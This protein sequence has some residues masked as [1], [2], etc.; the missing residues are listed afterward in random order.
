M[1]QINTNHKELPSNMPISLLM[2]FI[3]SSQRGLVNI[4]A[5]WFVVSMNS[6][7][8]SPFC[9]WSR[10][11]WCLMSMCLV[12]ECWIGFLDKFIALVLSHLIGMWSR[13]NPKSISCCLIHKTWAQQQPAAIY[14]ASAV[15]NATEF[16]FLLNQETREFPRNWQVP[17]VLFLSRIFL[18]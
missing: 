9:T 4:S 15:D 1:P 10:K 7:T 14:S 17:E 13:T 8:T 11:K 16:Y 18:A 12:L 5:S 3:L 6:N 2:K